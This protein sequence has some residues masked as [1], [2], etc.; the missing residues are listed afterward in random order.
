MKN[1]TWQILMAS[2]LCCTVV[3]CGGDDDDGGGGGASTAGVSNSKDVGTLTQEE[4]AAVCKHVSAQI[5]E[6]DQVTFC[7]AASGLAAEATGTGTCADI[8]GM[9]E[10]S[11]ADFDCAP[12]ADTSAE[13]CETDPPPTC[14]AEVTVA[15]LADCVD[16]QVAALDEILSSVTCDSTVADL[17][18]VEGQVSETPTA[19]QLVEDN[20]PGLL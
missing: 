8:V 12:E 13:D 14:D 20:C 7:C 15:Q 6:V 9:C 10:A 3:A 1:V 4:S 18:G 2:L 17:Q 5:A 19:C 11:P 16:A